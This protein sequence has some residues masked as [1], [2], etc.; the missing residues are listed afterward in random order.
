MSN[1]KSLIDEAMK[2]AQYRLSAG[3]EKTASAFQENTIVKEASE[4]ANALEYMSISSSHDGS[5]AG[6]AR[7]EIIRDFYKSATAERLGTK[8][9][10]H[11]V[12]EQ[13]I[14]PSEG[15]TKLTAKKQSGGNPMVSASPD[16]TGKTMLESYKQAQSGGTTL[17]DIL[18]HQKE[19]GDVGEMAADQYMSIPSKNENANRAILNDASILSGVSKSS[20]KAPVRKRLQEAFA[21]TSDTLGDATVSRLFPLASSKGGLKKVAEREDLNS[22]DFNAA[23]MQALR[24]GNS[25]LGQ[26][27]ASDE[28]IGARMM[29]QLKG[30]L[31]GGGLGTLGG[32]V[33]GGP[34]G[35]VLGGGL[36][37]L[38]GQIKGQADA[39]ERLLAARGLHPSTMQKYIGLGGGEID[40]EIA[41]QH[42]IKV[43]N[44]S[45][46][47]RLKK[48]G[49]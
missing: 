15:K 35:A 17:Y 2:T 28:A 12:G 22:T 4:L 44:S 18:M 23:Q 46:S 37:L 9:A 16:S 25:G 45:V 6:A 27:L 29:G 3:V 39:D 43:A 48:L 19:A 7:A 36:G 21:S 42:G 41:A 24:R 11:I 26:F 30:G 8:L 5:L 47:R 13:A 20:A 40:R 14:A 34:Q 33:L 10:A 32:A 31:I 1:Y 38:A 49:A